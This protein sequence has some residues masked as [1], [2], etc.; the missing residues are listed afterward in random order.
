MNNEGGS[1]IVL[2]DKTSDSQRPRASGS[3]TLT[4]G[5]PGG[6]T[7]GCG[8]LLSINGWILIF[9][10]VSEEGR[11]QE[12]NTSLLD[13]H[14]VHNVPDHSCADSESEAQ[15]VVERPA[16]VPPEF[17]DDYTD[18]DAQDTVQLGEPEGECG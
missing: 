18:D 3:S 6:V 9:L 8:L 16:E 4:P 13:D 12:I 2:Q 15:P 1:R 17:E 7:C 11:K 14:L 10:T 5:H